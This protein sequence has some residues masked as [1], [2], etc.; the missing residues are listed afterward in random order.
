MSFETSRLRRQL[1]RLEHKLYGRDSLRDL[2]SQLDRLEVKD[3]SRHPAMPTP[4]CGGKSCGKGGCS[5]KTKPA[6]GSQRFSDGPDRRVT[7][8]RLTDLRVAEAG[9][10]PP[11]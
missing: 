9:S 10:K 3:Y 5:C 7:P 6:G 2:H 1:D 8:T 4:R 11:V